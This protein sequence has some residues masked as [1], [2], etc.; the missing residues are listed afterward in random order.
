MDKDPN[1]IANM[2]KFLINNSKNSI[3][4]KKLN[5]NI[6][7]LYI[8]LYRLNPE[9]EPHKYLCL[10]CIFGAFMG[11][12]IGSCCEFSHESPKNHLYIFKNQNGLFLPGEVTDDSEMAMSAAF[13]Y[14]D[15]I[16]ENPDIMQNLLYYYYG[17][18]RCSGP[19][20]IGGATTSA[21]RF[22]NGN[23]SITDT[24]FKNKIVKQTNW[25][26]LANGFLMRISTFITYYYY[27]HIKVI[28]ETIQNYFN[29]DN[30]NDDLPDEIINLYLDI[31]KESY[32]NVEITHPNYENGISSAVF[33][34]MTFVGM[35]TKDARKV[36]QIFEHISKSKKF[37]ESHKEEHLKF[38][39]GLVQEKYVKIISEIITNKYF[40]VYS[41]MGYY[42]HGFKLCVYFLHKYPEMGENKDNDL[43]Y[44]I[45]CEI[46]DKGGDTD[47]NCA[48]VGAMIGPL[49]G[50][51]N[52]SQE[53]FERFIKFVP[54]TRC[55]FNSA[56]MY[57]YVK[58]LEENLLNKQTNNEIN[59]KNGT[60]DEEKKEAEENPKPI[61]MEEKK[62]EQTQENKK[63]DDNV[64]TEENKGETKDE[65]NITIDNKKEDNNIFETKE[66][67]EKKI[68]NKV[69]EQ[70]SEKNEEN[71][72]YTA[73]KLIIQ[74]L[75]ESMDL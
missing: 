71:F 37:L 48:I 67:D 17:I 19:K 16:N 4:L 23:E 32:K 51:K 43:Y 58:Y 8:T 14:I 70:K 29:K 31:Y 6:D 66:A 11:D 60:K 73:Y 47:T 63:E 45:M 27:T 2:N 26:S 20:D 54:N 1:V 34:I 22:F 3:N 36:F 42:L 72:K 7:D 75:N 24:K 18:W 13:A 39:A 49:I 68:T 38:Y 10:S 44:K 46:C 56:F 69:Q 30:P 52:F 9:Q 62:Q 33:T 35:I 61:N 65:E 64:K 57:V 59:E 5:Q 28:Y 50:Y 12:S 53:L 41:Q 40:S 21:L 15:I 55:Q 74:F 25:D